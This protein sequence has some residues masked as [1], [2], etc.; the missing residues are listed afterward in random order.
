ME[1]VGFHMEFKIISEKQNP[2]MKRR[3]LLA[4]IKYSGATPSKAQVQEHAAANL[5]AG[6]ENVE[7]SK[8]LS[9]HGKCSGKVWIKIWEHKK[10]PIY[11]QA[12]KKEQPKEAPQKAEEKK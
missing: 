4:E 2:V 7:V 1:T 11:S 3:E 5:S 6:A 12:E 9:E 8:I 10:V